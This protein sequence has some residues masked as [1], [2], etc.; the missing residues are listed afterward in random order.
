MASPEPV[1]VAEAC[2]VA[3]ASRDCEPF[4]TC[5]TARP[6]LRY[7]A[8]ARRPWR[9]RGRT[10]EWAKTGAVIAATLIPI[11]WVDED[12]EHVGGVITIGDRRGVVE[13]HP[14]R[15]VATIVVRDY[16]S[17]EVDAGVPESALKVEPHRGA[18]P[19][20]R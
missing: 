13:P 18:S 1:M 7:C 10:S 19:R 12:G 3:S 9:P 4:A 11:V 14:E 16:L 2:K 5:S 17:V 6:M 20:L 8:A 15:R